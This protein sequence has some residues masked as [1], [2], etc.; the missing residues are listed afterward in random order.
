MIFWHH[1]IY[2]LLVLTRLSLDVKSINL[3]CTLKSGKN[4]RI[5]HLIIEYYGQVCRSDS[6][7]SEQLLQGLKFTTHVD[8]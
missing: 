3:T 5:L 7:S 2:T 8:G 4:Q 6:R 1:S